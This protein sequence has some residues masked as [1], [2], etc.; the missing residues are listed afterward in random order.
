MSCPLVQIV[1]IRVLIEGFWYFIVAAAKYV[2]A[3][4]VFDFVG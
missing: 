1:C 2:L 4:F 3:G